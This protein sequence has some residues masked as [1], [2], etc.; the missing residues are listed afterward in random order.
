MQSNHDNMD[1]SSSERVGAKPKLFNTLAPCTGRSTTG[2]CGESASS[3]QS[4]RM[5]SKIENIYH[6]ANSGNYGGPAVAISTGS[7]AMHSG[8]DFIKDSAVCSGES[9]GFH[10]RF[11]G[12]IA[13]ASSESRPRVS[14]GFGQDDIDLCAIKETCHRMTDVVRKS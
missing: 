7:S 8:D 9:G 4:P 10:S 2:I 1:S 3:L 14:D 12:A 11:G 6:G 13:A 5:I